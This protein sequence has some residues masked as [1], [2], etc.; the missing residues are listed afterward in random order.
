MASRA[1]GDAEADVSL[2]ASWSEPYDS[3]RQTVLETAGLDAY[4]VANRDVTNPSGVWRSQSSLAKHYSWGRGEFWPCSCVLGTEDIR[5]QVIMWSKMLLWLT[6]PQCCKQGIQGQFNRALKT[7]RP[8]R[9]RH[10]SHLPVPQWRAF[11]WALPYSS[12]ENSPETQDWTCLVSQS[13][14]PCWY[15][16]LAF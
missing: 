7:E 2:H 5:H 14:V 3:A 12:M 15:C 13:S 9:L 1:I 4:T 11:S 10:P 16:V 6:L 8:V